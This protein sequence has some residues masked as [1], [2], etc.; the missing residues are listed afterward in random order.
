[1]PF[2]LVFK[3]CFSFLNKKT[4]FFLF[5][6]GDSGECFFASFGP[7]VVLFGPFLFSFGFGVQ[8]GGFVV[9]CRLVFL[10]IWCL[11]SEAKTSES[12]KEARRGTYQSST[13]RRL[14]L[15]LKCRTK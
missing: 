5:V 3:R 7:F 10:S 4:V 14:D 11:L 1:M 12:F 8:L 13:E 15:N 2:F 6:F 9:L